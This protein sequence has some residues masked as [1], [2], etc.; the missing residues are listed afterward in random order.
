MSVTKGFKM[1]KGSQFHVFEIGQ[2]LS[3]TNGFFY[4][5]YDI[6]MNRKGYSGRE[7]LSLFG[8]DHTLKKVHLIE[9][10]FSSALVSQLIQEGWVYNGE[11][12]IE[13]ETSHWIAEYDKQR[14]RREVV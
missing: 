7:I 14:R 1:S 12:D 6:K 8:Y 2:L 5:V 4:I 11:P 9:N 10:I 13:R 3:D